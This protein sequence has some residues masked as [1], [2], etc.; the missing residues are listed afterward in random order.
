MKSP[1]AT[2]AIRKISLPTPQLDTTITK[3]N[4]GELTLIIIRGGP[5]ALAI[6]N[7]DKPT[8][9][10]INGSAAGAGLTLT[11]PAAIRLAWAGAKVG[12][13]FA[14]RGIVFESCSAFYLP[15][16][17]GLSRATH[18]A[19]TGK[20]Y[21]ATD[22]LVNGL[23]SQTYDTPEETVQAAVALAT[24]IAENTSLTSTKLMRDMLVYGLPTPEETHLIES[25]ALISMVGSKDNDEGV[26][27]FMEKRRPEYSGRVERERFAFWPWWGKIKAK[28]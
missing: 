17:L 18:I 12:I 27:S 21:P 3:K 1:C 28:V 13:P 9:V 24:D 19:M 22:P 4:Y 8:I 25:Q 16:L 26:A 10:A 2:F 11:L 5:A 20:T 23:F 7:C 15:K 14:R 6:K